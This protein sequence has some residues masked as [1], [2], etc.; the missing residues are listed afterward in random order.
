[1]LNTQV[2]ENINSLSIKP[3][4]ALLA[5]ISLIGMVVISMLFLNSISKS[6]YHERETQTQ[7]FVDTG[8]S[9]LIHFH[10]LE[11][12]GELSKNEAQKLAISTLESV[13]YGNNGYLWINDIEGVMLMHP[14]SREY[15]GKSMIDYIDEQGKYI[16]RDIIEIA[17]S[18]GGFVEYY[19]PKPGQKYGSHKFS[20]VTLFES[21]DWVLGTGVYFDDI[22]DEIWSIAYRALAAIAFIF[23]IMSFISIY[24]SNR[25]LLKIINMASHDPLTSLLTRRYLSEEI[26]ILISNH[27]RG[28]QKYLAAIFLDIDFFKKVND[29]YGH[30]SGDEVLSQVGK[31]IN[32]SIRGGDLGVRYGGEEF[33]VIMLCENKVEAIEVASRI[34]ADVNKINFKKEDKSF[35]VTLSGGV[36]FRDK[37]ENFEHLLG[38]ADD[39][40]YAAKEAGR[41]CLIY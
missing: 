27:D 10:A 23:A 37:D 16:F 33:V 39:N 31:C 40:L 25:F 1:M 8:Y 41:D 18:G 36:A 14:Y 26:S 13:T 17:K 22:K 7:Q 30:A 3:K 34:C 12:K 28:M 24:M 15:L 2:D 5:V 32:Q 38:R 4:L 20:T 6:L 19:W 21:W 11:E 35:S 9:I 29:T